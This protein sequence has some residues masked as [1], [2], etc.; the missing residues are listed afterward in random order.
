MILSASPDNQSI[1]LH[2]NKTAAS[3]GHFNRQL[4]AAMHAKDKDYYYFND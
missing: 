1:M 2:S 3:D 4:N